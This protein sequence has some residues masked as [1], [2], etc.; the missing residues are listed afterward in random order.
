MPFYPKEPVGVEDMEGALAWAQEQ[1]SQVS[2]ELNETIALELRLTGQVPKR[3]REGMIVA[4]DG[5]NWDPGGG[6]GIYAYLS[7]AWVKL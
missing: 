5:T 7:G 3:P 6:K 4:A 2:Q 1:F